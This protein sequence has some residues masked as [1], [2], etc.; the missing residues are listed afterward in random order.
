MSARPKGPQTW[1]TSWRWSTASV[2]VTRSATTHD[3]GDGERQDAEA[4]QR[5]D[6]P[7][8]LH[9]TQSR[10]YGSARRRGLGMGWK[11]RS[12]Y[13]KVLSSMRLQGVVDLLDGQQRLP[14]ER[15]VALTIDRDGAAL[16]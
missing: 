1:R 4:G 7:P 5:R 14:G 2:V 12:Q 15:Q 8:L 3:D 16:A 10:A 11:Q 13:P 6:S 9:A